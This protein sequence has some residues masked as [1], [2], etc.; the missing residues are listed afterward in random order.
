MLNSAQMDNYCHFYDGR[1]TKFNKKTWKLIDQLFELINQ[2]KPCGDDNLHTLWFSLKYEPIKDE[3]GET[4]IDE[5]AEENIWYKLSTICYENVDRKVKVIAI[6]NNIIMQY[7]S[8]GDNT[9]YEED[10][11]ELIKIKNKRKK[12]IL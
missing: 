4:Y 10:I 1:K 6:N 12:A 2:I 5:F 3:E 7:I 8:D 11:S 9:G